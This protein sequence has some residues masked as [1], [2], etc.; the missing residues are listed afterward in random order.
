MKY[1]YNTIICN[2]VQDSCLNKDK[3]TLNWRMN[4]RH[5]SPDAT[6]FSSRFESVSSL[7]GA[8]W[9]CLYWVDHVSCMMLSPA[10][11]CMLY[12]RLYIC[13]HYLMQVVRRWLYDLHISVGGPHSSSLQMPGQIVAQRSPT[14]SVWSQC[15]P[16]VCVNLTWF[17]TNQRFFFSLSLYLRSGRPEH[18]VPELSWPMNNIFGI[19]VS[20]ILTTCPAQCNWAFMIMLSMPEIPRRV[21]YSVFGILSCLLP[22][23]ILISGSIDGKPLVVLCVTDK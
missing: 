14:G 5:C 17:L 1:E 10:L 8:W 4:P 19:R 22:C 15:M 6:G 2:Q 9:L 7:C 20:S 12:Y 13:G 21:S 18:L 16:G 3:N 11:T 23:Y